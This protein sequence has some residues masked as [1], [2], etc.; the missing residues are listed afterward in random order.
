[1]FQLLNFLMGVGVKL[2]RVTAGATAVGYGPYGGQTTPPGTKTVPACC[3]A[4]QNG[5]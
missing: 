4:F 5:F 1:M 2:H 3:P